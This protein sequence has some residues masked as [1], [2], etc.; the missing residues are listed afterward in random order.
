MA[1]MA[2]KT[3]A[4][5]MATNVI[6]KH[7]PS[8]ETGFHA[9][10]GNYVVHSH[11]VY[12]NVLNCSYEG[13]K[14]LSDLFPESSFIPYVPPGRSLSLK[15][16]QHAHAPIFFLGNHGLIVHEKNL[17]QVISLH[18]R[19]NNR[20]REELELPIFNTKRQQVLERRFINENILF[21]DQVIYTDPKG[22]FEQSIVQREILSAY[23][24]IY[25]QITRLGL[26]AKTLDECDALFLLSMDA[27]KHRS[28][29][30]IK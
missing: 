12:V 1:M 8:M 6:Q 3:S 20:I 23:S 24:Y 15:V 11:S 30:Q 16:H 9:V 25:C 18:E 4:K 13:P 26:T 2:N 14:I 21:P 7:R 29:V 27:E 5:V 19:V 28:R 17:Q 22:N 10:L